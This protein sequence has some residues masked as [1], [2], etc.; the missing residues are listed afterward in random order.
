MKHELMRIPVYGW[1]C[2]RTGMIVVDREANATAL[3]R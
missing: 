1:Y 3:R 2:A